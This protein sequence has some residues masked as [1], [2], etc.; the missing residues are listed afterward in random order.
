MSDS[1]QDITF[2]TKVP[3]DGT[4]HKRSGGVRVNGAA[5]VLYILLRDGTLPPGEVERVLK[6]VEQ[7]V[8][9]GGDHWFK[10]SNGWLGQYAKDLANRLEEL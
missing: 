10:I 4:L 5:A 8:H 6:D 9:G 1:F 3:G 7:A 2:G